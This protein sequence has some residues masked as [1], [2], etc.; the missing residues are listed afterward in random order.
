MHVA[1]AQ[2]ANL[3][4]QQILCLSHAVCLL[5]RWSICDSALHLLRRRDPLRNLIA[6][7]PLH[8]IISVVLRPEQTDDLVLQLVQ[9]SGVMTRVHGQRQY[10]PATRSA[11]EG[12]AAATGGAAPAA[13]GASSEVEA[14]SI[15]SNL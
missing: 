4:R 15:V 11:S 5:C 12:L 13:G 14:A 1:A 9:A 6:M 8:C 10:G 3:Q 7:Q 2:Q